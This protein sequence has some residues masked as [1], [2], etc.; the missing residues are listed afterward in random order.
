VLAGTVPSAF[1]RLMRSRPVNPSVAIVHSEPVY[2]VLGDAVAAAVA[3]RQ[4]A[5]GAE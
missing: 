3:H 1:S 5:A 2:V 4:P